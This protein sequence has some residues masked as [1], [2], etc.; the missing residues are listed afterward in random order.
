MLPLVLPTYIGR[1]TGSH[2]VGWY[3]AV[4]DS[5]IFRL[6]QQYKGV[7][8]IPP[9][10][11]SNCLPFGVVANSSYLP[12]GSRVVFN[13]CCTNSVVPGET[14]VDYT[15]Y[16][17]EGGTGTGLI[18]GTILKDSFITIRSVF[19][20]WGHSLWPISLHRGRRSGWLS[21]QGWGV[22]ARHQGLRVGHPSIEAGNSTMVL[23]MLNFG[24]LIPSRSAWQGS[25]C[26][27]D[28]K[29]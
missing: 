2:V 14:I 23:K 6:L 17:A 15:T 8:E 18:V 5:C 27:K 16:P 28:T 25:P 10:R 24:T 7:E 29:L 21:M 9:S 4:R 13:N 3:V 12:H 22:R 11:K 19:L 26:W 20:S 1:Q